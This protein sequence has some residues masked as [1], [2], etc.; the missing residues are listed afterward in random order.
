MTDRLV[1][2]QPDSIHRR[3]KDLY[4]EAKTLSGII[5]FAQ[6]WPGDVT[7]AARPASGE[8]PSHL[9][10]V[11]ASNALFD[12]ILSNDLFDT[13][14]RRGAAATLALHTIGNAPLMRFEP[15]RLVLLTENPL[16]QRLTT[17]F[18]GNSLSGGARSAL[19]HARRA[20]LLWNMVR[21]AGGIQC[22]GYPTWNAYARLSAN[23]L[24][25]FDSRVPDDQIAQTQSSF[26]SAAPT[27][28][29]LSAAF[30][31]RLIAI[32]G[33]QY[34]IR[35]IQNLPESAIERF[36]V[37]GEGDMSESLKR[38]AHASAQHVDFVGH[39]PYATD[40]VD[41]VRKNVDI[42]VLPHTQGDPAGTYLESA[43]LGVP[44]VGF[45]NQALT[46]L[47][48]RHGIGW[49]VPMRNTSGLSEKL[50]ELV[51]DPQQIRAAG[52][53]GIDFVSRHTFETE[54]R[55]RVLHIR[56]VAQI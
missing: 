1:V 23:P 22:N 3:G 28:R 36:Y 52:E 42:M 29:P 20:P 39:L 38:Q 10:H 49:T 6:Q 51:Q 2:I 43:A 45:A 24:L 13:A 34:A 12:V 7:V 25:F 50:E 18:I 48:E 54:F 11:S 16:R 56:E 31:G 21:R 41:F 5:E 17:S 33:P 9:E 47:A 15:Q 4:L 32:K 26:T 46:P 14:H 30:S 53:R 40:W 37:L 27:S 55:R 8:P 44:I 35:A 19:G